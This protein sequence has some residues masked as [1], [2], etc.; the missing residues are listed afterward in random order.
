MKQ[1]Y[2][3]TADAPTDTD[4]ATYLETNYDQ[5]TADQEVQWRNWCITTG[6]LALRDPAPAAEQALFTEI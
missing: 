6:E 3:E 1:S 5:A 4:A 2:R